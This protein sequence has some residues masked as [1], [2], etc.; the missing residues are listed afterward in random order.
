MESKWGL[1]KLCLKGKKGIDPPDDI[2]DLWEKRARNWQD[3]TMLWLYKTKIFY[4]PSI[5]SG[6]AITVNLLRFL[7]TYPNQTMASVK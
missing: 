5:Y 3:P 2:S 1:F 7:G 4:L 6:Y